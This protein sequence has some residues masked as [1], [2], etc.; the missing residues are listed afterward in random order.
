MV[1]KAILG[2]LTKNAP[3]DHDQYEHTP[4]AFRNGNNMVVSDLSRRANQSTV[5][6]LFG[7]SK[8]GSDN[9]PK[10]KIDV[11]PDLDVPKKHI[12]TVENMNWDIAKTGISKYDENIAATST[13]NPHREYEASFKWMKLDDFIVSQKQILQSRIDKTKADYAARGKRYDGMPNG[14]MAWDLVYDPSVKDELK[15]QM[16]SGHEFHSLLLLENPDGSLDN[17]F[18]EGRHR[19]IALKEIGVQNVP[20]W[21]L[22]KRK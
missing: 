10:P 3:G 12:V 22:R 15:Q 9:Y 20:V 2:V 7:E 1:M 13:N 4:V 8:P 16:Q 6:K 11:D 18:Q 14:Q 17:S 19:S 5:D 21:T